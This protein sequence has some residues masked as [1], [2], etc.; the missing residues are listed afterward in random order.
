MSRAAVDSEAL[1]GA[2][3]T[4]G[5]TARVRLPHPAALGVVIVAG[6]GVAAAWGLDGV[7][8]FAFGAA[9]ASCLWRGVRGPS[10]R[11][12]WVLQGM[13]I[14]AYLGG[15]IYSRYWGATAPVPSPADALW[16][17]FY[18]LSYVSVVL[19]ARSRMGSS[20]PRIWVDGLIA[21][22]AVGAFATAI[23]FGTL[24]SSL[25]GGTAVVATSLAY[26]IADLIL[27]VLIV[28]AL[29]VAPTATWSSRLQVAGLLA[30]LAADVAFLVHQAHGTWHANPE[31]RLLWIGG[32]V[33]LGLSAQV[34]SPPRRR[35]TEG[36]EILF[37]LAATGLALFLLVYGQW[38]DLPLTAI[39]LALATVLLA[40]VRFV[41]AVEEIR[42]LARAD[43]EAHSDSLTGLANR[44]AFSE[45]VA[46]ALRPNAGSGPS[47][48][49]MDLDQFADIN[50]TLGYD[51]ANDVLCAVADRLRSMSGPDWFV[52]RTGGDEF[53][54][55]VPAN[56]D[57]EAIAGQVRA[58][59]LKPFSALGIPL[60]LSVAVGIASSPVHG[61]T[62]ADLLT[63]ADLAVHQAKKA[64]TRVATFRAEPTRSG[65]GRLTLRAE[66]R[67]ALELHQIVAHLQP[68]VDLKSGRIVGA[69]A[70]A[71][72]DHPSRGMIPPGVFLQ[73]V[74]GAG[75]MS[76]LTGHMIRQATAAL[77]ACS[78]RGHDI[79]VSV[80]I[81]ATDLADDELVASLESAVVALGRPG[82]RLTIEITEDAVLVDRARAVRALTRIR[83]LGVRVSVDDYGTGQSSLSYVRD[84]PLDELKLDRSFV[85]GGAGDVRRS[86][87]VRSTVEL[88]HQL[89]LQ[90][91]A[92]GIED[93]LTGS[94]LRD[95]GC[96]LGQ[97]FH[98]ARPVPLGE[99]LA[100]LDRQAGAVPALTA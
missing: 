71:R 93:A 64:G 63:S 75:L 46:E 99:L 98:F 66:I 53:A 59:L 56:V 4:S 14:A 60:A 76:V 11:L 30:F 86:A 19:H 47:V 78:E 85:L 80:N 65:V 82:G 58:E 35:R 22:L 38:V 68:Q 77:V 40:L 49:F 79:G 5:A 50:Q 41:G 94:W 9:A 44:Q 83:E 70:L 42:R 34:W 1:R 88:A 84:L 12:A 89:S 7:C 43:H 51:T 95:L 13:G 96:D 10:V 28:C 33:L 90:A 62:A 57:T 72:W 37:P 26:P 17:S 29:Q 87:I 31:I 55:L 73:L 24:R 27:L 32:V 36:P 52:A 61:S 15:E 16:L 39:A 74:E 48:L 23:T 6:F 8:T 3:I 18:L 81:S 2:G 100:L 97:G 92:E 69:E 25:V 54:L 21:G 20:P 91:V 45:R 67:D